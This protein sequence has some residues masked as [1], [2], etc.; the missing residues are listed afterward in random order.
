VSATLSSLTTVW[1]I[2][3]TL[4]QFSELSKHTGNHQYDVE[5]EFSN[6]PAIARH[7]AAGF[8][9]LRGIGSLSKGRITSEFRS[10]TLNAAAWF[11]RP[12]KK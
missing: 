7:E 10:G 6:A 5:V 11:S 9:C 2:F 12:L 3:L 4:G 8:E 1:K